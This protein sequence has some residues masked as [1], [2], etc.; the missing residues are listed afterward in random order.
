MDAT[1]ATTDANIEEAIEATTKAMTDANIEAPIID[2]MD[3]LDSR[4][5]FDDEEEFRKHFD[6]SQIDPNIQPGEMCIFSEAYYLTCNRPSCP[7]CRPL[8]CDT[9]NGIKTTVSTSA[10]HLERL[11]RNSE[12][13]SRTTTAC[14]VLVDNCINVRFGSCSCP[15]SGVYTPNGTQIPELN[16][17][18][19]R[20]GR[21]I[22]MKLPSYRPIFEYTSPWGWD[23]SM[24]AICGSSSVLTTGRS[25]CGYYCAPIGFAR[26][27]Y[28]LAMPSLVVQHIARQTITKENYFSKT[29]KSKIAL[30]FAAPKGGNLFIR[31]MV[32][33]LVDNSRQ[34]DVCQSDRIGHG[35]DVVKKYDRFN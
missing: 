31:Q 11:R 17:V 23:T 4:D 2:H 30:F 25:P 1:K 14:N 24:C 20:G 7:R 3:Q 28:L 22:E 16:G 35:Y 10:H 19:L 33:F 18:R 15:F 8:M 21:V 5:S 26:T 27:G 12:I 9:C 13:Q 32:V 34:N 6:Y 29:K